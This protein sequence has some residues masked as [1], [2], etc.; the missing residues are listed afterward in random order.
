MLK[1]KSMPVQVAV[2]PSPHPEEIV[3]PFSLIRLLT[4]AWAQPAGTA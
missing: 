2:A 4:T 1:K 3:M